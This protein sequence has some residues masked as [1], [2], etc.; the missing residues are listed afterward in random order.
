MSNLFWNAPSAS[1]E[2]LGASLGVQSSASSS[3]SAGQAPEGFADLLSA[4][5]DQVESTDTTNTALP[6]PNNRMNPATTRSDT[7]SPLPLQLN[8]DFQ[9]DANQLSVMLESP[10]LAMVPEQVYQQIHPLGASSQWQLEQPLVSGLPISEQV[11]ALASWVEN[12]AVANGNSEGLFT[13]GVV[14]QVLPSIVNAIQANQTD[15]RASLLNVQISDRQLTLKLDQVE[16]QLPLPVL[17][18][19]DFDPQVV[20]QLLTAN[21]VPLDSDGSAVSTSESTP[22]RTEIEDEIRSE[23]GETSPVS[24]FGNPSV[25]QPLMSQITVISSE[26]DPTG[27]DQFDVAGS[28]LRSDNRAEALPSTSIQIAFH[29]EAGRVSLDTDNMNLPANLSTTNSTA[30]LSLQE[31]DTNHP[32]GMPNMAKTADVWS[33]MT[34][35]SGQIIATSLSQSNNSGETQLSETEIQQATS[36]IQGIVTNLA[37]R[38]SGQSV[39]QMLSA[40]TRFGSGQ[41]I[42]DRLNVTFKVDSGQLTIS[43][44]DSDLSVQVP[45]DT[46]LP[47][48]QLVSWIKTASS[49]STRS[50]SIEIDQ[51]VEGSQTVSVIQ[52]PAVVLDLDLSSETVT[53]QQLTPAHS[54]GLQQMLG[55]LATVMEQSTDSQPSANLLQISMP[56]GIQ[57]VAA[58]AKLQVAVND[59]TIRLT[60]QANDPTFLNSLNG[61][62]QQ[63]KALWEPSIQSILSRLNVSAMQMTA[64]PA[65]P[66][67]SSGASL[68]SAIQGISD[69]PKNLVVSLNPTLSSEAEVSNFPV[70]SVEL[71]NSLASEGQRTT[72]AAFR[73]MPTKL[74][75]GLPESTEVNSINQTEELFNPSEI[76]SSL[77]D[78]PVEATDEDR[79]TRMGQQVRQVT[80]RGGFTD[81]AGVT[82]VPQKSSNGVAEATEPTTLT[83]SMVS[84]RLNNNALGQSFN[85]ETAFGQGGEAND[86]TED[87][88]SMFIESDPFISVLEQENEARRLEHL[89]TSPQRGVNETGRISPQDELRSQ[90]AEARQIRDARQDII[91]EIQSMQNSRRQETEREITIQLRPARLG[92][93]VV[94]V[95]QHRELNGSS[96][97]AVQIQASSTE[98]QQ[99]LMH[100]M[101]DLQSD[102]QSQGID[103]TGLEVSVDSGKNFHQS[104]S[105]GLFFADYQRQVQ[106]RRGR[107][108]SEP[109]NA[110]ISP[111]SNRT[112]IGTQY[113]NNQLNLV[114]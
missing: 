83:S 11:S 60:L 32:I 46:D 109:Q 56:S 71:P 41:A 48:E 13:E 36:R 26:T 110:G 16:V 111:T 75:A 86:T 102:L 28:E 77:L 34:R 114:V 82:T 91:R 104:G 105:Q 29:I 68:L 67:F 24:Q 47:T 30:E 106:S 49:Q 23:S 85:S 88:E 33:E 70:A 79:A 8:L 44:P 5:L 89:S 65:E 42:S 95:S 94:R 9:P 74:V 97:V 15:T 43:V 76:T 25:Q 107:N 93:L 58:G 73:T 37:E 35:S 81:P 10:A 53:P 98:A 17:Q 52:S 3:Q 21:F 96:A 63:S 31:L 59:N 113:A 103:L 1:S 20:A 101:S 38:S 14:E 45:M 87:S 99:M 112:K 57:Q 72:D 51:S 61:Q 18:D 39:S 19:P 92:R 55:T 108:S 22:L 66:D 54:A 12:F 78:S 64:I 62:L 69:Q 2:G 6:Q 80:N 84:N 90:F 40:E 4:A 100:E 50:D 27:N 7:S